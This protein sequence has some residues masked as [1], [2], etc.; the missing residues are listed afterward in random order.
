[1]SDPLQDIKEKLFKD[2]F[3]ETI[4][5]ARARG[6]C[7]SCKQAHVVTSSDAGPG[8]SW[9][10]E[11]IREVGISGMCEHCFDAAFAEPEEDEDS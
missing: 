8:S 4:A 10:P 6:G 9:T 2:A 11:G 1:M 5:E 3:G 7:V